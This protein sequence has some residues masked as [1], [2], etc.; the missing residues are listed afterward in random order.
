MWYWLLMGFLL[1]PM[2]VFIKLEQ[3]KWLSVS[4]LL[5]FIGLIGS[6]L[7]Q[8]DLSHSAWLLS[9]SALLFFTLCYGVEELA[10]KYRNLQLCFFSIACLCYSLDFWFQVNALSWAVAIPTFALVVVAFLL[11]LPLLDSFAIQASMVALILW[12]MLWAAGELWHANRTL[13]DMSS[14]FGALLLAL[15]VLIWAL[16]YFR[17]PFKHSYAWILCCYFSAHILII[18]PT[19]LK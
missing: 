11:V 2:L 3:P 5:L 1:L 9:L 12:Q 8:H 15:T 10:P 4:K 16:H 17:K 7:L 19:V 14:L 18:A 13:L 6:L